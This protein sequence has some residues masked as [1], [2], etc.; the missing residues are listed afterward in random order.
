MNFN[1]EIAYHITNQDFAA[2]YRE[3]LSDC[4]KAE[5]NTI[6]EN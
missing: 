2:S 1:Y 3:L 6:L 4:Q 5:K